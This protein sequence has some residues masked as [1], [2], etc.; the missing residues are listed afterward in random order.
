MRNNATLLNELNATNI[1]PSGSLLIH[2]SMKSLGPIDGGAET[3]IDALI[4][5]M[6][7]GLLIMPTH[8]WEPHNNKENRFDPAKE[9]SC[10]GILGELFR[11]RSGVLRSLHPTH[12]VAALGASAANFIANEERCQS[13]CPAHG[14][15]SRLE[16]YDTQILFLGCPLSKNT[17]IHSIEEQYK[18]P[19][20]LSK[21]FTHYQIKSGEQW[22]DCSMRGHDAPCQDIS[23]NYAKLLPIFLQRG[24]AQQVKIAES[25]SYLCSA[26]KMAYICGEYL[27]VNPDFFMLP[28][29]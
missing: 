8:T 29:L 23:L 24:A 16:Q 6:Q 18:I 1:D 5:F 12:S 22:L 17:F 7:D 21:G 14:V 28:E 9:P 15:W 27:K 4:E 13:P 11:Q 26:A 25:T 2:S 3:V 10:V 19:K 20:R